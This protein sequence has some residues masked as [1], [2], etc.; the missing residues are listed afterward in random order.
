[1]KLRA[2]A[3]LRSTALSVVGALVFATLASPAGAVAE[4]TDQSEA[5]SGVITES[6][7]NV[8]N[9]NPSL[10]L[11]SVASGTGTT[12]FSNGEATIPS[13][14]SDGITMRGEDGE[15]FNIKLP[16]ASSAESPVTHFDGT[17]MYPGE[18]SANSVIV[19]DLGVQMLTTIAGADAPVQYSYE[20]VLE[21]GQTLA[22]IGDGAAVV[23]ADGSSALI[24]GDAWAV[25]ANGAD[26]PTSYSVEG[27][28][29]TQT[30]EHAAAGDFAYPVVADPVWFLPAVYRCLAGLTLSGPQITRIITTGSPGSI[31]G[32]LGLAILA[33][34][35]GK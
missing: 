18:T 33:C 31:G 5:S 7:A 26:V 21:E 12:K 35:R 11:D 14:L 19:S 34:L 29:L 8:E 24:V 3:T 16:N 2:K 25:D 15:R 13:D 10:L 27:A 6:L 1:M 32:A 28:T 20:V 30:V 17:V 4:G 9:A 23:N 22:L